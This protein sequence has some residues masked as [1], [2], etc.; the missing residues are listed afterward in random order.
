[1]FSTSCLCDFVGHQKQLMH[2]AKRLLKKVYV[3]EV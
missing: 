1:M 2:N 3:Y